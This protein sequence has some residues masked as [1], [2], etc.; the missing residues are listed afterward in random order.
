MLASF[1]SLL[2]VFVI[3]LLGVILRRKL[4]KDPALWLGAEKLGFWVLF[5]CLLAKTLINADL[6]SG[7][8]STLALTLFVATIVYS[9]LMLALK[10]LLVRFLNMNAASY[11]TIY[12]V[13]TRWNGFIALA[14]VDKLYGDVGV[15]L[16][17]VALAAMVPVL[18][19][20][21]VTVVTVLL[22]DKRPSIFRLARSVL[23]NPLILGCAVG[24]AVNLLSIPI[25]DPILT[26][27]D[28]LG[29][30]ALGVGLVLVGTGLHIKSALKPSIPAWIGTFLKLI[31]FP[32]FVAVIAL[33]FGLS[34]QAF[35]IAIICASVPTA[36]NGYLLAKELG[37]DAPLYATVVTLQTVVCFFTIPIFLTLAS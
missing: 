10:P 16:V 35:A 12:Q 11:S 6:Q 21:N 24:L 17:A 27:L 7:Q 8:A 14:I 1:E 22:S 36:M 2:P 5:P 4:V 13:S 20:Q 31:S 29:R 28:V 25:Y 19:V 32:A 34:G 30:A 15:S 33:S 23:T 3:I 9:V 18:N 26:T 37:G